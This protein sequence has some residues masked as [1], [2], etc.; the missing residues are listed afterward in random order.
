MAETVTMVPCISGEWTLIADNKSAVAF[1]WRDDTAYGKWTFGSTLP[2]AETDDF[3][4][5]RPKAPQSLNQ[6]SSG[7]KIW[8]MPFGSEDLDMEVVTP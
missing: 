1:Q 6:L 7:V 8:A 4:T 5:L 2:D 3:W